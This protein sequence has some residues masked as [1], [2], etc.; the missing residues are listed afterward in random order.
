MNMN[1]GN[2]LPGLTSLLRTDNFPLEI[3]LC[4]CTISARTAETT[5]NRNHA[6][7]INRFFYLLGSSLQL[8]DGTL[9][10]LV[11]SVLGGDFSH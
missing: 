1:C 6:I 9:L 4:A 11:T 10:G 3:S 7:S 5:K 8:L 2:K